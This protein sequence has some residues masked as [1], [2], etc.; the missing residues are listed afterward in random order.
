MV[1]PGGGRRYL[2]R[3]NNG[4][5]VESDGAV[6]KPNVRDLLGAVEVFGLVNRHVQGL[7]KFGEV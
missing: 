3:G 5:Q 6:S 2:E 4:L 7:G 1:R